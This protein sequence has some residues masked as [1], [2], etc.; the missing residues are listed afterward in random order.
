MK[1]VQKSFQVDSLFTTDFLRMVLKSMRPWHFRFFSTKHH[2]YGFSIA[3]KVLFDLL[4]D[5][6][7]DN[8]FEEYGISSRSTVITDREDLARILNECIFNV[9]HFGIDPHQESY[10]FQGVLWDFKQLVET[11]PNNVPKSLKRNDVIKRVR[12]AY[13]S[14]LKSRKH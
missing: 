1:T 8:S 4:R 2:C 5:Y 7:A 13:L 6:D 3:K 10:M 14:D 12:T 9:G 11:F